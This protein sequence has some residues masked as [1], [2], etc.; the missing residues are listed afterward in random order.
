MS[1][2]AAG[3][4]EFAGPDPTGNCSSRDAAPAAGTDSDSPIVITYSYCRRVVDSRRGFADDDPAGPLFAGLSDDR[5]DLSPGSLCRVRYVGFVHHVVS[6]GRSSGSFVRFVR[7][8]GSSGWVLGLGPRVGSSGWVVRLALSGLFV[9][10]VS[11][12]APVLGGATPCGNVG[13]GF[14][15]DSRRRGSDVHDSDNLPCILVG[16][17]SSG[18]LACL[19]NVGL[20]SANPLQF[21]RN[22]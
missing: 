19:G 5:D 3:T 21:L 14:V 4:D 11:S 2:P 1:A 15:R 13:Q 17:W 22:R 10:F 6:Q 18:G 9:G 12:G 7:R 16:A 8:V 20:R